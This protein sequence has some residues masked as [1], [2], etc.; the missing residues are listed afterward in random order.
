MARKSQKSKFFSELEIVGGVILG[1]VLITILIAI[2]S[3]NSTDI[4][5]C[6]DGECSDDEIG[7]CRLDCDWCGD[8]YCQLDEDCSKCSSD[9]G[10]C[11]ADSFCGDGVCGFGECESACWQDC[12][13]SECENG[14]CEIE[15]EEDCVNSPNDCKCSGGYCDEDVK[16]CIY[17]IEED[18]SNQNYP[19]IFIHGHSVS[20]EDTTAY[21]INAFTEMQDELDEEELVEDKGVIIPNSNKYEISEGLWGELDKPISVRTTYYKG[22]VENDDFTIESED[23]KSIEE[24]GERLSSVVEIIKHHTGK[25]KVIL[26]THS[27]GGLVSRSYIKNSGGAENV[28]ALITIGTPNHGVDGNESQYNGLETNNIIDFG[29]SL[30]ASTANAFMGLPSGCNLLH[31]GKECGE[32]W[33]KSDF[34]LNLNSEDETYGNVRYYSI[35]GDCCDGT[36]G[37]SDDEAVSVDSATLNGAENT[38]IYGSEIEGTGTFHQN[39]IHP[40]KVPKVYLKLKEILRNFL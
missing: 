2:F 31:G 22:L 36:D 15:K 11:N 14:I 34:I 29:K 38:I 8:G 26:I 18:T 16:R 39:L 7:S 33:Y 40:S 27:M 23:K 20:N 24:Y 19:I 6:G 9:C 5:F 12:S 25:D 13:F 37:T 35:I 3:T 28:Y 10:S 30:F 32:M 4:K 1:I 17:E 21:S